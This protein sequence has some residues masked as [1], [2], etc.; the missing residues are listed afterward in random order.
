MGKLLIPK[1]DEPE[2][3]GQI[4][5][6]FEDFLQK[7]GTQLPVRREEP[8]AILEFTGDNYFLSNFYPCQVTYDGLTYQ[9][10]E[11][12]FQA[13][14]TLSQ[15]ERRTFTALT[16]SEAKKR[17]RRVVLRIDWELVK[18]NVM[19]EILEAKFS[20]NEGLEKKLMDTDAAYLEEGNTWGDRI[21][22]TVDGIGENHLGKLLM[23][24]RQKLLEKHGEGTAILT[25]GYY[26]QL[27]DSIRATM[28]S[29]GVLKRETPIPKRCIGKEKFKEWLFENYN[30]PDDNCTL[31]PDMLDGILDYAEGMELEEQYDFFC[32][33][34]PSIGPEDTDILRKVHC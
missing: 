30:V 11:A 27:A 17:G 15:E 7:Y 20:Q 21:W 9:N 25:G 16:A 22:G 18:I 33:M 23:E 32:K 29:W 10:S 3:V 19:R 13:Q 26:D 14:K 34:F 2:F 24:V 12:A 8:D 4:I 1:N 6:I 5:D 28:R 31:A